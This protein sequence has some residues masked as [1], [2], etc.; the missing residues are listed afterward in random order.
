MVIIIKYNKV[1]NLKTQTTKTK[2]GINK[3][4]IQRLQPNNCKIF[5]HLDS[6]GQKNLKFYASII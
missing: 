5:K 4:K 6:Y 3:I 2:Q 1:K